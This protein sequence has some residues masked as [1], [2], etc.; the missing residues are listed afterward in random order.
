MILKQ[1]L[2]KGGK[3]Q[4]IKENDKKSSLYARDCRA[5]FSRNVEFLKFE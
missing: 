4:F 2:I 1:F 3:S 5:S